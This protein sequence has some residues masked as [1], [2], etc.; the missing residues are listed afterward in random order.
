MKPH[1]DHNPRAY[2][3]VTLFIVI[4]TALL[5]YTWMNGL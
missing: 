4:G 1:P 5:I 3:W 2:L